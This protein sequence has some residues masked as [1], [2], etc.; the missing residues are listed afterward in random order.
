[1][2][3]Q[4]Q[5]QGDHCDHGQLFVEFTLKVPV[6]HNSASE[7]NRVYETYNKDGAE[8]VSPFEVIEE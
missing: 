5:N 3:K 6:A 4:N 1:M 2:S 8:I 7:M